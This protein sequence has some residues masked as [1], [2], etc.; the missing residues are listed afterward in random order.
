MAD[1]SAHLRRAAGRHKALARSHCARAAAPRGTRGG[2]AGNQQTSCEVEGRDWPSS[3]SASFLGALTRRPARSFHAARAQVSFGALM[4]LSARSPL[5]K[6]PSARRAPFTSCAL[7]ARCGQPVT[8]ERMSFL[9]CFQRKRFSAAAFPSLEARK[10]GSPHQHTDAARQRKT[11]LRAQE[12]LLPRISVARRERTAS[13]DS[14]L[15]RRK[16]R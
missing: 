2:G 6:F 5:R 3:L 1:E 8:E 16:M 9:P 10:R 7:R 13:F 12:K 14:V 11:L 4:Q 15:P